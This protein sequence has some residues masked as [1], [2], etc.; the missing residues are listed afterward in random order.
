MGRGGVMARATEVA[1]ASKCAAVDRGGK[2]QAIVGTGDGRRPAG[3]ERPAAGG[4]GRWRPTSFGSTLARCGGGRQQAR[5]VPRA[6]RLVLFWGSKGASPRTRIC[7]LRPSFRCCSSA[8]DKTDSSWS[9]AAAASS[10][11]ATL[12]RSLSS[13]ST[14]VRAS[15]SLTAS[16]ECAMLFES[17]RRTSSRSR[18]TAHAC[19][20][21]L[22]AAT[23]AS[24]SIS[25]TRV[26]AIVCCRA[27]ASRA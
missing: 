1:A 21:T 13:A 18:A 12:T 25:D 27:R 4:G 2:Q 6:R 22:L 10:S 23:A 17:R 11:G 14:V 19:E 5:K 9:F 26:R 16:L 24:C 3:D 7:Q 15:A 20:P 8:N